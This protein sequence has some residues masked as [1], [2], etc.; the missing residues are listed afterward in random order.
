MKILWQTIG[1]ILNPSGVVA[2]A[3]ISDP[4]SSSQA[5]LDSLEQATIRACVVSLVEAQRQ[6]SPLQ[7]LEN[8]AKGNRQVASF[9]AIVATQASKKVILPRR[10]GRGKCMYEPAPSG[11]VETGLQSFARRMEDPAFAEPAFKRLHHPHRTEGP[12]MHRAAISEAVD[13]L[14]T[15]LNKT[16]VIVEALVAAFNELPIA[17]PGVDEADTMESEQQIARRFLQHRPI[18]ADQSKFCQ[19]VGVRDAVDKLNGAPSLPSP[20][21]AGP[22]AEELDISDLLDRIGRTRHDQLVSQ[23]ADQS[24]ELA[25]F[26]SFIDQALLIGNVKKEN[27]LARYEYEVDFDGLANQESTYNDPWFDT[28]LAGIQRNVHG[29]ATTEKNWRV[30]INDEWQYRD[31]R[32]E[33]MSHIFLNALEHLRA[34]PS[35]ASRI[36]AYPLILYELLGDA[37][38]EAVP[39][40]LARH[41]GG[42]LETLQ[43]NKALQNIQIQQQA[44]KRAAAGQEKALRVQ[45]LANTYLA[46]GVKNAIQL[47]LCQHE[48]NNAKIV[49]GS[50]DRTIPLMPQSGSTDE[51]ISRIG[52]KLKETHDRQSVSFTKHGQQGEDNLC[53][54]RSAW[55]SLFT[56]CT[57]GHLEAR[58]AEICR[59]GTKAALNGSALCSIAAGFRQNPIEFMHGIPQKS[60]WD[61]SFAR[62]AHLGPPGKVAF[63]DASG[64]RVLNANFEDFLKNLLQTIATAFRFEN[65]AIMNEIEAL[66]RPGQYASSDMPVALH[67]AFAAP[68]LIVEVGRTTGAGQSEAS[69]NFRITVRGGTNTA[70]T[71]DMPVV[72]ELRDN[73]QK[74]RRLISE[75]QHL[76]IIWLE[77]GH[78]EVYLPKS[79]TLAARVRQLKA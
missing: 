52:Q 54:L 59:P 14:S 63:H 48:F 65:P 1:G 18:A 68:A 26:F 76:P 66:L 69:V 58:L 24:P 43:K 35:D 31:T 70:A 62:A 28:F 78:F 32:R 56:A 17:P 72:D 64:S 7:A 45:R 23:L 39:E 33:V 5:R 30:L 60:R 53:W 15:E 9:A 40:Y 79:L 57:P 49:E 55:I 3:D 6:L 67:R 10:A 16:Q 21:A 20:I 36:R 12:G 38:G 46:N 51:L 29:T 13:C 4:P 44:E 61:E 74:A 25:V 47:Q 11:F 41:E 42:V 75:F 37:V 77:N 19:I 22:E 8:L 73:L 2:D 71:I 34:T 27:R 50:I